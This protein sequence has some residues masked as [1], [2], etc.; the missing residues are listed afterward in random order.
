MKEYRV[1]HLTLNLPGP[2][3]LSRVAQAGAKVTKI[4]PPSGDPFESY[5]PEWYRELHQ[6]QTV[7]R[8]DLKNAE[9]RKKLD[10]ILKDAHLF[11]TSLRPS[12]LKNLSLDEASLKAKFPSLQVVRLLGYP[13]PHE[14]HPSHDLT[15]QAESGLL[16]PPSLPR[17][18]IADYAAAERVYATSLLALL[19]SESEPGLHWTVTLSEM[20]EEFATPLK[21]GMTTPEG[22][23]GGSLP[24]Y[25]IYPVKDGW[26][27]VAALEPHFLKKLLTALELE[28]S[29]REEFSRVFKTK[30]KSEWENIAKTQDIPLSALR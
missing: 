20:A 3:A 8:L 13:E 10:A 5:Y 2:L 22:P 14:D 17:A 4:E 25:D 30:T 18:L 16:S 24:H 21:K 12:A 11:V 23:L 19:K 7:V 29:S 28:K 9:Q 6:G 15:C 27:A 26:I 1:V